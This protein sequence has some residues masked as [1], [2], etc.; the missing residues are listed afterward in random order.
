M[1]ET[2]AFVGG[3]NMA[4]ALIGGLLNQ[5]W[6]ADGIVVVEPHSPQRENLASTFGVRTFA[7]AGSFLEEAAVVVWA[8]KPQVMREAAAATAPFTRHAL[9]VSIAAG[10]RIADLGLWLG[11]DRVVRAMPNLPALVRS[12]VTGVCAAANLGGA[13]RDLAARIL[14]SAGHV[15]WVETEDRM[16]AVT[17]VSGS[18]P[19]YVL[20]FLE[21]FQRAAQEMG[22]DEDQASELALLV[23]QGTA[24]L[25]HADAASFRQL[26]ER[27][28]SKGGTTAAGTGALD[29]AG[30]QEALRAA[31]KAAFERAVE[32]GR[33]D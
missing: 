7:Q 20:H 17:A 2:I 32:L 6:A 5:G 9:H 13:D 24:Q 18:G 3:G 16:N 28:S 22:F 19:G 26:R 4:T 1:S 31:V 25:A 10:I 23:T 8:V 29:A 33:Q 14:G 30:T 15:F 12:G 11:T 21:G 27:V